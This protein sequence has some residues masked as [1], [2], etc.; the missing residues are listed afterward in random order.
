M[1]SIYVWLGFSPKAA[2]MLARVQR[3]DSTE[4]LKVLTNK[5]I[6]DILNVMKKPD[7]KNADGMPD[8]VQQV[9]VITQ[10]NL[11]LAI[12]PFHHSWRCTLDWEIIKGNEDSVCL[13]TGQK[14][15]KD[16]CK[17][18]NVLPKIN[19]SH[20]AGMIE[21]IKEYLRWVS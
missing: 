3:Q 6:N 15:L 5:I 12:F 17:D 10:E 11:T 14:K 20:M 19:K 8:R 18:P 13:M 2:K 1:A 9:P 4:R 16:E 21:A 7:S